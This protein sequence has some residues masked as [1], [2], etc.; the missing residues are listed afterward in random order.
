MLTVWYACLIVR[1]IRAEFEES[2]QTLQRLGYRVAATPGTAAYYALRGIRGIVC[3]SKPT[4]PAFP[5]PS[6]TV[7]QSSVVDDA[8]TGAILTPATRTASTEVDTHAGLDQQGTVLDWI[9]AK[10]VDLVVNIPEGSTRT[11]EFTAGYLMRRTA[12]DFG[13]SLLTNIK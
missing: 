6:Q 10:K 11:D 3:L 2:L 9:R 4:D 13:C 5:P 7:T 8:E 12:V 1:R